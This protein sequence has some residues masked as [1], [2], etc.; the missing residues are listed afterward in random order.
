[1]ST[2]L[3]LNAT[4]ATQ[5]TNFEILDVSGGAGTYNASLFAGPGFTSLQADSAIAGNF[6]A[7]VVSNVASTGFA[8]NAIAAKGINAG[9]TSL[10]IQLKTAVSTTD[11]AT[12][13]LTATDGDNLGGANGQVNI[14]VVSATT[15]GIETFNIVSNV[16]GIDAGLKATS[17]TNTIGT[18]TDVSS[19]AGDSGLVKLVL[20]GNANLTITTALAAATTANLTTIDASAMTGNDTLDVSSAVKGLTFL[21]GSGVDTITFGTAVA[22]SLGSGASIAGNG[23]NDVFNLGTGTALA[24]HPTADTLVYK[25]ATDT[26][27]TLDATGTKISATSTLETIT[28]FQSVADAKLSHDTIDLTTFGFTSTAKGVAQLGAIAAVNGGTFAATSAT[29][30]TDAGGARGIAVGNDGANTYVFVDA[31]HDGAFNA[32]QDLVIK[33]VGV[34]TISSADFAL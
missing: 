17:Y 18:L 7:V 12:V 27:Q 14:G 16:N 34:H 26:T 8:F 24:G 33:M 15:G 4:S 23:G 28:A 10:D 31:N 21:G 25:A 2:G 11:S 22:L 32:S 6:G 19:G 13:T 29:L 9:D 20:S 5:I 30:F 1:M 3:S